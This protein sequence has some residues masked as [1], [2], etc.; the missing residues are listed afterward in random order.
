M[1]GRALDETVSETWTTLTPDQLT[2]LSAR[3]AELIV[4]ECADEISK[5]GSKD[6]ALYLKFHFGVE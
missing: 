1:L 6:L 3:F 5:V 4:K 2:K